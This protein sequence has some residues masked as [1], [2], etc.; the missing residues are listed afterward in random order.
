M[1]KAGYWYDAVAQL[2]ETNS[3]KL[4]ELLRQEGIAVTVAK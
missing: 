4:P 2:V 1:T 3:P